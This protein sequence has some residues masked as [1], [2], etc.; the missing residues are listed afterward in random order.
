MKLIKFY[1]INALIMITVFLVLTA[2]VSELI[3]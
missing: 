2:F 1:T 3:W